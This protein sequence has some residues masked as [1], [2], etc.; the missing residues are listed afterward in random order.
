MI[1]DIR[2]QNF[3]SYKNASFEFDPGVNIIV[4]P[5]ASGKTNLLEA[6][7][8]LISGGSYRAKDN[9]M[10]NFNAS[11][12]RLDTHMDNGL[13]RTVKLT[14]NDKP[15]KTYEIEGK[16]YKRLT[17]DN[18]LPFVLFE[19]ENLRL[20][21]GGPD[22]RRDYLDDFLEQYISGY[23]RLRNQYRRVLAQR[24]ALLKKSNH[25]KE[26][27][28]FPWN[29]RLCELAGQVVR[30]RSNLIADLNKLI[31]DLYKDLSSSKIIISLEYITD[32]F[33]DNYENQ[34]MKQ[35]DKNI[36]IDLLRGFTGSGPHREDFK[37]LFDGHP[38]QEVASR[39]ETRTALLVFKIAE[40]KKLE[41]M[42]NKA[43][44][45]LLDDV[46]SELD[47]GRRRALTESLVSYQVFISTTDA[48]IAIESFNE[49]CNV[50]ALTSQ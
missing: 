8:M 16:V 13:I 38:A 46:F 21:S 32:K 3:R 6:V 35:L 15:A 14:P 40:L 26:S 37:V 7:Q 20:L 47:G 10:V 17:L 39:G 30:F 34:L 50:I 49:K 44:L 1:T 29:V 19:P 2:L 43:P 18:R 36:E 9:E 23:R 42:Y 28:L 11:W 45:I 48:D 22:R 12:S 41:A 4:G 31:V 5:N 25:L 27:S 24:N 33:V